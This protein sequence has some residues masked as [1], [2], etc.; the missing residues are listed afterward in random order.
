[1]AN[2]INTI[3]NWFRARSFST[4]FQENNSFV[5]TLPTSQEW[6]KKFSKKEVRKIVAT[7]PETNDRCQQVEARLAQDDADLLDIK[8]RSFF[9]KLEE[10]D[11]AN[12]AGFSDSSRGSINLQ[13]Y[14]Q[15]YAIL[16]K[17]VGT[18][19]AAH[20]KKSAQYHAFERWIEVANILLNQ[21]QNYEAFALVMLRLSV[22]ETDLKILDTKLS[23]T[24]Y[25][26]YKALQAYVSPV[27]NFRELR[28]HI[29]ANNDSKVF[30]PTFL[31]SR[32][33]LFLNEVLGENKNLKSANL[34][35]TH[36]SYANVKKKEEILAQFIST[37]NAEAR[38]LSPHL[39]TTY[40]I[41]ETEYL[42]QAEL[43]R[44]KDNE[45]KDATK[46]A[47]RPRSNS[48]DAQLPKR[49]AEPMLEEKGH[50]RQRSK[51][52]DSALAP[53]PEVMSSKEEAKKYHA[54]NAKF[55][56]WQT[57]KDIEL[58]HMVEINREFIR[59]LGMGVI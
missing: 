19:I 59:M 54:S 53:K 22:V 25:D 10:K 49:K 58:D 42:E 3:I 16:D 5:D 57:P 32:D 12:P 52:L 28:K 14:L 46:P 36:E 29:Q 9:Q 33:V 56:F 41:L 17:Y 20:T 37:K 11:I 1:M 39:Q 26:T 24:A 34:K 44:R 43:Q 30:R 27:G 35:T 21:Y 7:R 47:T 13:N 51:S 2:P 50:K 45:A 31:L 4:W 38:T 15:C 55:M 6:D 18:N 40:V 23:D 48:A 8:L